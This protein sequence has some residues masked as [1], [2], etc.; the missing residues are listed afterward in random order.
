MRP[1]VSGRSG[2]LFSR[3]LL[4]V[5]LLAGGGAVASAQTTVT[6]NHPKTQVVWGTARG[7]SFANKNGRSQLATRSADDVE[8]ERRALLKFDT[9]NTIPEGSHVTSALLTLTVKEGSDDATRKIGAYQVT[10]SWTETEVTWKI[11]RDGQK[12]TKAG[13]DLGSKIDDAVVSNK[14]GT[15]VTFDITPLVKAAVA[16]DLGSSPHTTN[17]RG[18]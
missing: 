2:R 12:W 15:K 13:I 14:V 9:Q 7:G 17:A 6:L 18:R 4:S 8:Y 10:Q 16:G 11:R 3:A 1:C 5:T